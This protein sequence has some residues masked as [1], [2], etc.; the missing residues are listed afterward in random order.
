MGLL[1]LWVVPSG[2]KHATHAAKQYAKGHY[3]FDMPRYA[4]SKHAFQWVGIEAISKLPDDLVIAA[5]EV[6]LPG[7]LN[8][9]KVLIDMTGLNERMFAHQRFTAKRMFASYQPDLVYM[10]HDDYTNMHRSLRQSPEMRG[11]DLY[12]RN[13]FSGGALAVAIRR[14]SPHFA[15]LDRIVKS[16]LRRKKKKKKKKRKKKAEVEGDAGAPSASSSASSGAAAPHDVRAPTPEP[17]GR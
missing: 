4:G 17:T 5:T 3:E 2:T 8:P 12:E 16:K 9:R 7:A 15:A 6:G 1:L 11:Y 13:R 10:P 14:D